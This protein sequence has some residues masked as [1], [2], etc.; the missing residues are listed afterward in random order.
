MTDK[1]RHIAEQ[2]HG[3]VRLAVDPSMPDD[4]FI[5]NIDAINLLCNLYDDLGMDRSA[6]RREMDKLYPDMQRRI[7]S[8]PNI[9]QAMPLIKSLY[10]YIYGRGF[11][12]DDRGAACRRE[13][14]AEMCG[15]VV[16]AYAEEPLISSYHYIFA[17]RTIVAS[18][19]CNDCEEYREYRKIIDGYLEGINAVSLSERVRRVSAY[20]QSRA[21][22][23]P[24][25][26]DK[27]AEVRRTLYDADLRELDDETFLE[28]CAISDSTPMNELKKRA[29]HSLRMKVEYLQAVAYTEFERQ[30]RTAAKK[31]WA[32]ELKS[33]HDEIIGDIIDVRIESR[34]SLPSLRALA[35]I[36]ELRLQLAEV[37]MSDNETLYRRLCADRHAK[38]H[39]ALL[40]KYATSINIEEKIGILEL[41]G[42][43]GASR[44]SDGLQYVL[45]EACRLAQDSRLSYLQKLRLSWLTDEDDEIHP[46]AIAPLWEHAGNAFDVATLAMIEDVAT[47]DQRKALFKRWTELFLSALANDDAAEAGSLLVVAGRWMTDPIRRQTLEILTQRAA[48]MEMLSLPERKLFTIAACIH[49]RIDTEIRKYEDIA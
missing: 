19:G 7:Y 25:A 1:V 22:T 13:A 12:E 3:M 8:K 28:W 49:N 33:I 48:S 43:T 29:G 24:A 42:T 27:W 37:A 39:K 18:C 16:K 45:D 21:I 9:Q 46:E 26:Q 35:T 20:L 4:D 31:A 34:M 17:L 23:E 2:L 14:L 10:R 36:F 44:D 41:L 32:K 11:D 6:I 15:E 5:A 40:K 38:L 30:E 47:A